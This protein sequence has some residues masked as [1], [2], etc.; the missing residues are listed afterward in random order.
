MQSLNKALASSLAIAKMLQPP[1]IHVEEEFVSISFIPNN[2][3]H[4]IHAL[5]KRYNSQSTKV[6]ATRQKFQV[7]LAGHPM[8]I[9]QSFKWHRAELSLKRR[10]VLLRL[11]CFWR[12]HIIINV[13]FELSTINFPESWQCSRCLRIPITC[14]LLPFGHIK[15]SSLMAVYKPPN[16]P[17]KTQTRGPSP[18]YPPAI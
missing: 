14:G 7:L 1:P 6:F 10:T 3:F 2:H 15:L 9:Q 18:S 4:H 12:F 8:L 5:H 17:P 13:N 11:V 16:P